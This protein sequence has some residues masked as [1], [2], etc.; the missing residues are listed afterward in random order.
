MVDASRVARSAMWR[1]VET[2]SNEVVSLLTFVVMVRL[3]TP[4][5]FGIVAVATSVVAI[6]QVPVVNG[7]AESLIQRAELTDT[8][9]RAA[10]AGNLLLAVLLVVVAVLIAWPL[11]MVLGRPEFPTIFLAL[12]PTMLLH[13]VNLPMHA[14]LRRRLEFRAIAMRTLAS[15]SISAV[16]GIGLALRG[17]GVWSLVAAQ[18][19]ALIVGFVILAAASEHRPWQMRW[20]RDALSRLLPV[21]RPVTIS[22]LSSEAVRRLD[23]VLLALFA[24]NHEVGLYFMISRIIRS[25][26]LITQHSIGEVG[27]AVFSRLQGDRQRFN[28][29][30]RRAWR[31]TT[32]LA[33]LCF[34]LTAA[35]APWLVPHVFGPEWVDAVRPLQWLA[36]FATGGTLVGLMGHILVAGGAA[37]QASRLAIAVAALQLV[38]IAIAAPYGLTVLA[39]AVGISQLLVVYPTLR[40]VDR[41]FGALSGRLIGDIVPLVL[42][43]CG[44]AALG[45]TIDDDGSLLHGSVAA[46]AFGIS[47]IA[48]GWIVLREDLRTLG[49]GPV[50]PSKV[51]DE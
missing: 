46:A 9:V 27:L 14:M 32:F 42:L 22:N 36:L 18:W 41:R 35:V 28:N 17:A 26:Q 30:L 16:V 45:L 43:F 23:S 12:A 37:R 10:F 2:A 34:G 20:N 31:V 24:G 6:L 19:V 7:L 29:T 51:S 40:I 33:M 13:G 4:D 44:L 5:M 38:A 48:L 21:A 39:L 50:L 11:A 15:V 1:V 25:V 47:M 3:L 49:R 8:E